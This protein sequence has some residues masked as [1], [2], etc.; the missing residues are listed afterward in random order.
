MKYRAFGLNHNTAPVA[1]RE[2][3]EFSDAAI[4]QLYASVQLVPDAEWL[5]ISTCNRTEVYMRGPEEAMETILLAL[6]GKNSVWPANKSFS[7]SGPDAVRHVVEVVSGIRSQVVGD[8]QILNQTKTAYR[9]ASSAGTLGPWM[10]RLMHTAFATAKDVITRTGLSKTGSSV[11]RN[12]VQTAIE[13]LLECN[14]PEPWS[15][16]VLGGGRMAAL[17]LQEL[18]GE[19]RAT[20]TLLNRTRETAKTLAGKY[21]MDTAPWEERY[22]IAS[23]VDVVIAATGAQEAVLR[24]DTAPDRSNS[25]DALLI[26]MAVPRNIDPDMG[27]RTGYTVLNIDE[28]L[29]GG[30]SGTVS[31]RD[32]G[33]V[34][35]SR[36]VAHARKLCDGAVEDIMAWQR[37][38][39]VLQSTIQTLYDTFEEVRSREVDHNLHRFDPASRGQIDSLTRSIMQKLLAIPVVRLKT[40]AATDM[41][42]AGRVEI[43]NALFERVSCEE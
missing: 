9:L 2:L 34:G 28:L 26:D 4:E 40:M 3:L 11:A 36:E 14:I 41:D 38:R 23:W 12:S 10:H 35:L 16:A 6:A 15:F 24:A 31:G 27:T 20:V 7:C 33:D 19:P 18:S 29:S 42:L 21:G 39:A 5:L 1:I 22:R 13:H 8:G 43:L 25:R 30:D 32:S 37:E 17:V